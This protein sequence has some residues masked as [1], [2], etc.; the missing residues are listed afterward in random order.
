LI[1]D[2]FETTP[3]RTVEVFGSFRKR[4][5]PWSARSE[6]G[7]S[8]HYSLA[9]DR[10]YSA[11]SACAFDARVRAHILKNVSIPTGKPPKKIFGQMDFP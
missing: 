10:F 3:P 1:R 7:T 11:R 8:I 9:K 4:P 6:G 2:N 5:G